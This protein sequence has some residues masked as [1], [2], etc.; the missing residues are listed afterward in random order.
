MHDHV[1][2]H[3]I[4]KWVLIGAGWTLYAL[5]FVSEVVVSRAYQGRPLSI[6]RTIAV[7]LICA[8]FWFAATPFIIWLAR[9]F[10]LDRHRWLR[11]ALVHLAIGSF[12]SSILLGLYVLVASALGLTSAD[13]TYLTAF[14]NQLVSTFHSELL[15]YWMVVGLTNGIDYYQRYRER[16]LRASQLETRLAHA[17]LE[18]LR[19]QLRPHFLFNTLNSISIL[20]TEDV[21]A[22]RRM[23]TRLA[24]L[25]RISLE[26]AGVHEVTLK[27]ELEFLRNYL[28]I[29]QTRF[30]DRL[31][32]RMN[33][34][35][36]V[37]DAR[38]PN[39][40]LQPL[41]ENAIRHGIAPRAES[42]LVEITASRENGR[43][44]LC[45]RDN[46]KGLGSMPHGELIKGI[47]LSN[48][49]ARLTQLYGNDHNFEIR[50]AEGEGLEVEI[51]IPF[52]VDVATGIKSAD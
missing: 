33:I 36:E 21:K 10:P 13:Q 37:L 47:G 39:L 23:L 7:W 25:L 34:E 5:F 12:V 14:R 2:Q 28:D 41:V 1:R 40:I 49:E 11:S 19:M 42:G 43:V 46:G 35:P 15:T 22:A 30:H 52:H 24:D 27:D 45:V 48:T 20:M 17:E 26:N 38:V 51:T 9:R 44:R 16:E 4:L 50:N 32:V 6:G 8:A 31:T 18:A 3:S 29:E